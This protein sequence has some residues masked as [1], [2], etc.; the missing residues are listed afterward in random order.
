MPSLAVSCGAA[1]WRDFV[2]EKLGPAQR[3]RSQQLPM[4]SHRDTVERRFADFP[5]ADSLLPF[6]K[7]CMNVTKAL[8][9]ERSAIGLL[10]YGRNVVL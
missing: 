5:F 3:H 6:P 9:L 8:L 7:T 10:H 1:S 4:A 2:V